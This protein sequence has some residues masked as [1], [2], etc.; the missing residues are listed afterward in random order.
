MPPLLAQVNVAVLRAPLD[1]PRML[2]FA[3]AVRPVTRLAELSPG[4]VWRLDGGHDLPVPVVEDGD[5]R[6]VVNLS[7][8]T[9][10]EPLH[11]Y[12]FRGDHGALVRNRARWFEP[13][14]GVPNALWWVRD[15]ARPT[16]AEGIARLRHLRAH[17]PTPAAFSVKRRFTP[18][19]RRTSSSPAPRRRP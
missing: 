17:G 14:T 19:G 11:A 8:W 10:Y 1:D 6:V 4:F 9:G 16:A 2:G 7:L 13:P 15:D 18:D 3:G 5:R 12:T